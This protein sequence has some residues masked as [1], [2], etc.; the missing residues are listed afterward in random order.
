MKRILKWIG[1]VL[2]FSFIIMGYRFYKFAD[3]ALNGV[4][5]YDYDPPEL[6]FSDSLPNIL[7]FTKTNGFIHGAS[8]EAS[9]PAFTRMCSDNNWHMIHTANG[10]AFNSDYLKKI[11]VIV[12]NNTSGPVLTDDQQESMKQF[13]LSGGGFIGIHAAGDGSHKWRWYRDE[14]IGA[15][16][17]H[18]PLHPQIQISSMH[19]ECDTTTIINCNSLSKSWNRPGEWYIFESN[20]RAT[21]QK[22]LYTMDESKITTDGSLLFLA[23][24]KTFGMGDDHPIVWYKENGAGRT[25][26]SAIGHTVESWQEPE[27]LN[28]LEQAII[29][30]GRLEL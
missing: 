1:I 21:G 5:D 3:R 11:D 8:I 19:I 16:Y 2:L 7:I 13:I 23:K 25:L 10:A 27:H 20:P 24:E 28:M 26:Y 15:E 14:I 29:W 30:T 22:V 17:S 4:K 12:W 18:H 6:V 9:L